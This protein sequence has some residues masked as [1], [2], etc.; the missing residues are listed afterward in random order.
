V[1]WAIVESI[2]ARTTGGG[3]GP[4]S[5]SVGLVL[6]VERRES[7]LKE[8]RM[9]NAEGTSRFRAC[10]GSRDACVELD[11]RTVGGTDPYLNSDDRILGGLRGGKGIH[12][13][14]TRTAMLECQ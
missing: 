13:V 9:P 3:Y 6:C 4:A 7:R 1:Y 11:N 5:E 2:R 8:V 14:Y 12:W 10:T